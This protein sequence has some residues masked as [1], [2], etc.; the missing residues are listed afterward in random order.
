MVV[1]FVECGICGLVCASVVVGGLV[2]G[3]YGRGDLVDCV[4]GGLVCGCWIGAE[5]CV[6][7]TLVSVES[8]P[9]MAGVCIS[10]CINSK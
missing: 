1:V 2:C 9:D 10:L 6:S 4:V 7:R 5:M 8:K 3:S